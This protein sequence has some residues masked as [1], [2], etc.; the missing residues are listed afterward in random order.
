LQLHGR[1]IR[2]LEV[3]E[4]E[5]KKRKEKKRKKKKKKPTDAQLLAKTHGCCRREREMSQARLS[6]GYLCFCA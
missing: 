2:Q 5:E 6:R 1:D 4:D 3:E